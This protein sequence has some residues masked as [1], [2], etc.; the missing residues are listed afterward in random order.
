MLFPRVHSEAT[1]YILCSALLGSGKQKQSD[2]L[3]VQSTKFN[4]YLFCLM[5]SYFIR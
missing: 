2:C 4:L 3:K 5:L 1:F